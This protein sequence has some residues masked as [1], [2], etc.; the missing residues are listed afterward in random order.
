MYCGHEYTK[1]NLE[2]AAS[3]EPENNDI[4]SKQ[5]SLKSV[6]IPSTIGDEL[7]F[8]PFMRT[9]QPNVQAFTGK[10]DPVE[11]MAELRERKNRF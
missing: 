9:N 3:V 2:F 11:C 4:K 8:N 5:A 6:S 7:K 1:K 10:R